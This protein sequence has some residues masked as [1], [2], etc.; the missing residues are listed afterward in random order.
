M[1]Q[2]I[3]LKRSSTEGKV[4][5][6]GNLALGELGINTYDGRIFLKKNDGSDSIEHVVTTD[7]ITTGSITITGTVDAGTL[8]TTNLIDKQYLDDE[9]LNA[10]LNAFTQSAITVSG[11]GTSGSMPVFSATHTVVNSGIR[12]LTAETIVTHD[13]DTNVIFTVSGSNGELLTV[14]DSNT[15]N[16]LEVNDTS[17]LDVFTVSATGDVSA[18][19]DI[20]ASGFVFDDLTVPGD[21][22]LTGLSAQA[23]E[24]TS[25]MINSSNV[26]G[27]R[28]L[29]SNAFTSTAFENKASGTHTL[30]SGSSQVIGILSS[31]NSFSASNGNASLNA[32]TQSA[33]SVNNTTITLTGGIGVNSLGNFTL[34]Q[35]SA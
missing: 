3:K 15:G 35:S 5:I 19:G 24:A 11:N 7:S 1:A 30:V 26:I 14:T 8:T 33:A 13:N 21:V 29:G 34:N 10:S 16:L 31:L 6:A 2:T 20:T 12:S 4:P 23:S 22:T 27:T 17:G 25:L 18:S 28:E 9:V 32:Y